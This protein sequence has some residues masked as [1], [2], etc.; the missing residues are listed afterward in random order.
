[1]NN[2]PPE[3]HSTS[4]DTCSTTFSI[5]FVQHFIF[6]FIFI[7]CHKFPLILTM[8]VY[9]QSFLNL[10]C[11]VNNYSLNTFLTPCAIF[12]CNDFHVFCA[13]VH[14]CFFFLYAISHCL[15]FPLMSSLKIFL[16]YS[17]TLTYLSNKNSLDTLKMFST[18]FPATIAIHFT[19]HVLFVFH[20]TLSP[21]IFTMK[22][23]L[24]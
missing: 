18:L 2:I 17:P 11:L 21:F 6:I 14:F 24:H 19:P 16:F 23:T 3:T 8:K 4:H 1:M 22:T 15:I 13:S 10:E 5:H 20:C 12:F 9:V 7:H